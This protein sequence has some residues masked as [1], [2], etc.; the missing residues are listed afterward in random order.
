MFKLKYK[1]ETAES[2]L[3]VKISYKELLISIAT[4]YLIIMEFLK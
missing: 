4:L 3:K 1:K 2:K